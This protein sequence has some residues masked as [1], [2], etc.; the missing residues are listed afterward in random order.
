[1][2]APTDSPPEVTGLEGPDRGG[3]GWARLCV[4]VGLVVVAFATVLGFGLGGEH[5]GRPVSNFGLGLAAIAAAGAC[6]LRA[7]WFAGRVRWGWAFIGLGV[8]SWGLGQAYWVYLE[9]F[10]GDAAPFP[11]GADLGYVCMIIFTAIGLL[12]LPSAA[13]ALANR[14][15]S[16][17]DGLM[18]GCSFVLIAWIFVIQPLIAVGQ[19]STLALYVSLAYPL[20]DVVMLTMVLYMLALQRRNGSTF[21]SLAMVGAGVG[22]FA[23]SDIGYAYLSLI[24]RYATGGVT[25][26]GWFAGFCLIL[27]AARKPVTSKADED[28]HGYHGMQPVGVLLPYVAV[29]G[30]LVT[31]VFWYTPARFGTWRPVGVCFARRWPTR[32]WFSTRWPSGVWFG[33]W[34]SSRFCLSVRRPASLRLGH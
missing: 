34:R 9:T 6:L 8:L 13:Q 26:I 20:G 11:S 4:V 15:R 27:L 14:V 16:V 33:A 30:S 5:V 18:V 21:A 32:V 22:A 23:A 19:D 2:A 25:D 10:R 7:R 29:L 31:T 3:R 28:G 24:G 12:I 17:L 1:M